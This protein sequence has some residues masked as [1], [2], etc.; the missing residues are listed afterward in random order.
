M[1]KKIICLVALVSAVLGFSTFAQGQTLALIPTPSTMVC[2]DDSV[3]IAELPVREQIINDV[4]RFPSDESYELRVTKESI[5]IMA[6]T[7]AG[8]FYAHKTLRQLKMS[9]YVRTMDIK[10]SPAF[11]WR[12]YMVDVG[13]NYQSMEMLKQQID[14]MADMKLNVF[15]F[16]LTENVAWRLA[17][18]KYPQLTDQEYMTRDG[19]L[20]YDEEDIKELMQYCADRHILFLMEIDMPGH[21]EAFKRAMGFDMQTDEGLETVLNILDE[22]VA[23]FGIKILHIGAD[24]V[25]ITKE[26]FLPKVTSHLHELGVT[27]VGWHP[28][29]DYPE[30]VIRQLWSNDDAHGAEDQ[31]DKYSRI[32]SRNLYINHMD[33]LEAIPSIYNHQVCDVDRGDSLNL[34]ATLCLWND[35]KLRRGEDNLT[36][37]PVYSSL[38][39][40]AERTWVGGGR[41][42]N[43]VGVDATPDVLSA[44][45]D[46]E[47]SM[48]TIHHDLYPDLPFTYVPQAD[49]EWQ[50]Y[51]P[52]DNG[53]DLGMSFAPESSTDGVEP[54]TTVVGGTI[55]WRHFW[56]PVVK[57]IMDGTKENTTLYAERE[58]YSDKDQWVPMWIG[59]YD[60]SR[61]HHIDSPKMG[62][63]GSEGAKIWINGKEI[64]PPKW[65]RGGR[66]G[67]LEIPFEDENYS[68]RAPMMVYLHKGANKILVKSPIGKYNSGIWYAPFKWMFT[69]VIAK[70]KI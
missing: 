34:G 64:M 4:H 13:R 69:A 6:R 9:E 49:I 19:G 1:M 42:D 36:H 67:D 70:D 62:T 61:S 21:S 28:G 59:F 31:G 26:D 58:I 22:V 55:I 66:K 7:Q 43:Y 48:M 37:N 23:K 17:I 25:R 11:S 44:F 65:V 47:R 10:D 50:V 38:M 29:G 45:R 57:G 39:A 46:F 63:W 5:E 68:M 14:F 30:Y 2:G 35:R 54:M 60:Y 32:D 8:L 12:G 41:S 56:D 52:Y 27:V 15:H 40:F 3:L 18:D 24:E 33:A 51:G 16:H 20:Y 53:G